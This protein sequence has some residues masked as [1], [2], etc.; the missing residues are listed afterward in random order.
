ESMYQ[1]ILRLVIDQLGKT[2]LIYF[3]L[4]FT[5][6]NF[7]LYAN[8]I[9]LIPYGF[10]IT[11]QFALTLSLSITIIFA[12]TIIG[13]QLHSLKFISILLPSGTPLGL[14]PL[15]VAIESISYLAKALS[16]GIRLGAN[17][18]A[19]HTLLKIITQFVSQIFTIDSVLCTI[20]LLIL[21][22]IFVM[23]LV[24]LE[25]AIAILQ[26]YVFTTLTCTY[27][28]DSIKLH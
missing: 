4:I 11:A 8:L 24:G 15:L 18:L 20:L 10:T 7:I 9:G 21:P 5:I 14:V 17:C 3:P 19:G 2:Q 16:L 26:S 13:F 12:T 1:S 22:I 23:A 27:I 28:K 25:L 6:F